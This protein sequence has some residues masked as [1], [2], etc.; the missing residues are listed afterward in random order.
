MK[1]H[2][3]HS[4][5]LLLSCFLYFNSQ[6]LSPNF[7]CINL[8]K[9]FIAECCKLIKW[10]FVIDKIPWNWV[11]IIQTIVIALRSQVM[12]HGQLCNQC[13][14]CPEPRNYNKGGSRQQMCFFSEWYWQRKAGR[15]M[16]TIND[17]NKNI[18]FLI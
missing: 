4:V 13:V 8:M 5:G 1:N 3:I 14:W 12:H 15:Q 16:I 11:N 17:D 18:Y 6:L 10:N 2:V 7:C 9:N